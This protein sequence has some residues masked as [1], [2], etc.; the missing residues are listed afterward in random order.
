MAPT[1]QPIRPRIMANIRVHGECWLWTGARTSDGYGVMGV[2]RKQ[3]RAHR[4]SYQEFKGE[5]PLG[6]QVCHSCDVPLCVNP[7]HLFVGTPQQN[8]DDMIAKGRRPVILPR[9][10]MKLTTSDHHR[11]KE[12]RESGMTLAEIAWQYDVVIQTIS[13]VCNGRIRYAAG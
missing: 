12:L 9:R 2:G 11:I 10:T 8:T 13:A 6:M 3:F 1:R 5:I 4:L 7:D